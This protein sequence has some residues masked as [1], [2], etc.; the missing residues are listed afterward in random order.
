MTTKA[1]QRRQLALERLDEQYRALAAEL[2]TTGYVLQGSLATRW[3]T[4]GKPT[5]RC[6]DDPDARHGPYHTWTYKRD[7]K[8]V[9]TYLSPEQAKLGA[10]WIKNNRRLEAIVRK[11][12]TISRRAAKL[13][14]IPSK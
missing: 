10:Q 11:M 12:R 5:C 14:D 13:N 6:A 7:A 8:T 1:E 3:M 4:C 2:A 9:C